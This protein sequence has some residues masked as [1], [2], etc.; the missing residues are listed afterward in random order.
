[1]RYGYI[2]DLPDHRDLTF[3]A[4]PKVVPPMVDL[5]SKMPPVYDQGQIGSCTANAI[6]AAVEYLH[7]AES[8]G[9]WVPSRLFLYYNERDIEGTTESDAGAQIRDGI[10]TLINNGVCHE[11]L[12]PY[13]ESEF[14]VKP[15][16]EAYTEAKKYVAL[17]YERVNQNLNSIKSSLALNIPVVVGISVYES[18]ESEDT[19]TT[20]LVSLPGSNEALVGGH[21][22]LVCGYFDAV[23]YFVVRNSWGPS[24]GQSGY[25]MLPYAYLLDSNL[26]QDFW[27]INL[28][29]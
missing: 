28:V 5:R 7:V 4:A 10:K 13:R 20:G 3:S 24:W 16:P 15:I 23:Q 2:P 11:S 21:A 9:D 26:A 18:F 17:K 19:A 1:M 14:R 27:A 12:Y 22:V 25:F 8:K 6:C 29:K